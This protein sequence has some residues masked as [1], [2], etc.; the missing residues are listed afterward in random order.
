MTITSYAQNFEDVMLWRALRHVERGCYI[1]VGAQDPIIDSV[2]LGFYERGWRGIHIEPSQHYA[3]LLRQSRPDEVVI[4][5]AASVKRGLLTLHEFPGTGLSTLAADIAKSHE[6][7]GHLARDVLVPCITLADVFSGCCAK[8]IHWLKIDVEGGEEQ[9]LLGWG[10]APQ[11]P[12]IIVVEATLPGTQ[13]QSHHSWEPLLLAKGYLFA[14][15]DG[16]SRFYVSDAHV[17]LLDLF[18]VGPNV[19][20]GFTFSGT[21]TSSFCASLTQTIQVL[22]EKLQEARREL[23]RVS[24]EFKLARAWV[25]APQGTRRDVVLISDPRQI[26]LSADEQGVWDATLDAADRVST[27]QASDHEAEIDRLRT[28]LHAKLLVLS[29]QLRVKREQLSG[30]ERELSLLREHL[31]SAQSALTAALREVESAKG[32]LD[33]AEKQTSDILKERTVLQQQ[34][35]QLTDSNAWLREETSR[36]DHELRQVYASRSWRISGPLRQLGRAGRLVIAA[37]K[38]PLSGAKRFAASAASLGVRLALSSPRLKSLALRILSSTP[39]LKQRLRQ[40]A[41]TSEKLPGRGSD[42]PVEVERQTMVGEGQREDGS[43]TALI[44]RA[45]SSVERESQT[46]RSH[47]YATLLRE[48]SSWTLGRRLS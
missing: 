16:L 26:E 39:R 3:S 44:N 43:V 13:E 33:V 35:Q 18:A 34:V 2:S 1:D 45:G 32:Q 38:V 7:S 46:A 20:D 17:D 25:D 22:D 37:A 5:A 23:A 27:D 41:A 12:W 28:V 4:Q 36:I 24:R 6:G 47:L 10:D 15:F 8:E 40:L 9:V 19:F 31:S 30:S 21:A 14:Y 11:R 48:V 42:E 29:G